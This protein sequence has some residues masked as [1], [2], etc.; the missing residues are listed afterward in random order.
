[1][2][3]YLGKVIRQ[4]LVKGNKL[5]KLS[6][7]WTSVVFISVLLISLFVIVFSDLN[8]AD[9]N[10]NIASA[11]AE[12]KDTEKIEEN[13]TS[14][15]NPD[16]QDSPTITENT[17]EEETPP[18]P[19][20]VT[21]LE[22]ENDLTYSIPEGHVALTFDDGP[23][24]YSVQ[25]IDTLKQHGV[26]ATFFYIGY[27]V[28]KYPDVVR[29]AYSNGFSI[30]S[31]SMNHV[32]MSKVSYGKQVEELLQST[33]AIEEITNEKV[34][35]F[36]PPYGAMNEQTKQMLHNYQSKMIMWN[37]DPKDWKTKDPEKIFHY[38]SNSEASG[39]IIL[40]HESQAVI[41]VLPRIIEHLKAQN[42]NVVGLK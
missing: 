32:K 24:K 17:P 18:N 8:K 13:L 16:I 31:H 42:L 28:V 30:G 7:K 3:E 22:L 36:R 33:K 5:P 2:T 38:I 27:N 10:M 11:E 14:T 20:V 6:F 25:I 1:M 19:S 12:T 40:L 35:L 23:S 4:L 21:D 37:K 9:K 34:S 41:D 15:D 26:G 29:H 39:S